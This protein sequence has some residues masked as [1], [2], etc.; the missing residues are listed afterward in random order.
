VI[1]KETVA[2]AAA[3]GGN[4]PIPAVRMPAGERVKSTLN[5]PS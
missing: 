4:A 2:D 3:T 5:C 1:G